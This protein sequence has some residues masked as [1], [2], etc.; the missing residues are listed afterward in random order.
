MKK[1][2][3]KIS[4]LCSLLSVFTSCNDYLTYN[5][6]DQLTI[7]EAFSKRGT[8]ER[9]FANVYSYLPNFED[10]QVSEF[11]AMG[12]MI[13]LSDEAYCS[14]TAWVNYLTYNQGSYN[15][16]TNS[17]NIWPYSYQGINQCTTFMN[18]INECPD[19]EI[20]AANKKIMKEEARFV[21]A[22]CYFNLVKWFGPVYIW[23]DQDADMS[24]RPEEVD[25]HPLD[26]CINFIV[27][28]LDKCIEVLPLTITDASWY[29]RATKGAAMALKARLLL[30]AASP[31]FN[32]CD[33]YKD[34]VNKD[35]EYLFPQSY[36]PNKWEVAAKASKEIIDLG[37]YNL[38]KSNEGSS[39]LDKAIK[40]Y[41][42]IFFSHWNEEIIFG[43][44]VGS[45]DWIH[46]ANPAIL[47]KEGQTGYCPSLK[48]VDTYPM[49]GSGRFPIT[50][51]QSDGTPIIDSKSG[52]SDEGFVENFIHPCDGLPIKAHNSVVG[53]DA[54]FYA[55]V[56][57]SGMNWIYQ[58]DKENIQKITFHIG[59]TCGYQ[60]STGYYTKVGYLWRRQ[61]DPTYDTQSGKWPYYTWPY[62]R[63]GEVYLNYAEACNEKPNREEAE[64]LKYINL[65]RERSGLNKLEEAYP[66][67]KGN[68]EL[69]RELIRKERMVELAFEGGGFRFWDV[70][71]WMIAE[72]EFDQPIIYGRN[73]AATNF[74]D[75]WKRTGEICRPQA[76][77]KKYYLFPI[78]QDQLNEMKN[79]T[80]NK[81]W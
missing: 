52:Y 49:E 17:Y 50:G 13:P 12:S 64:A 25:R 74:E 11:S 21:R 30:Y 39:T 15:P 3:L 19:S 69:L 42:G 51:Y 4:I 56:V 65:I 48:L 61:T 68:Q 44:Y 38:Y 6:G 43:R 73:V 24:I 54:R 31:L 78:S 16:S 37:L 7:D 57:W 26:K 47:T 41:Q 5:F 72:K 62:F 46:N 55:S 60:N 75:S 8:V 32:G 45:W 28:E 27:E 23:G 80:Q 76:F 20:S 9:Y 77:P 58:F 33:Y 10:R 81:G 59:G 63:L 71:R 2:I 18:H 22:Y 53:R 36:D 1:N 35:G 70:H 34:V 66:E 67:V 79:M 40:S 29:G 14:W